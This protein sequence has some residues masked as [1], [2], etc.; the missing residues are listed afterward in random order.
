[1]RFT[2]SSDGI[3]KKNKISFL[4][5]LLILVGLFLLV[6][7]LPQA[8]AQCLETET[9][10]PCFDSYAVFA[11]PPLTET[12]IMEN[13]A[14][15]IELNFD[16]WEVADRNWYNT[17]EKLEYPIIICTAFVA[18]GITH[19]RM[20]KWVDDYTISDFENYRDDSLCDKWYPPIDDGI[21]VKWDKPN[22]LS[23]GIG[24][25]QVI[26]KAMNQNNR[27]IDSFNIHVWSDI[28]HTGI[29]LRV[30]ETEEN[31]GIFKG[32]AYFT[33]KDNSSGARLFVEDSVKAEHKGNRDS[34]RIIYEPEPPIFS[35]EQRQM[36]QDYCETGI[37]HPDMM[38]IPQCIKEP[39]CGPNTFLKDGVCQVIDGGCE[40]DINGNTFWCGVPDESD[41]VGFYGLV[42]IYAIILSPV[43]IVGI[44]L[45]FIILRKRK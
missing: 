22:Y 17:L 27:A 6:V 36:M 10:E 8:Y 26:D 33:I 24:I 31:S 43:L 41:Q 40:P 12:S 3:E 44:I 21:K 45:A 25:L 20:T 28:D 15:N 14:K 19:Y 16:D 4:F 9:P 34:S 39:D 2:F 35:D 11:G 13:Y 1:M 5:G 38:G 30:T 42:E 29:Q 7:I 37:R 18:D 23:D 32:T